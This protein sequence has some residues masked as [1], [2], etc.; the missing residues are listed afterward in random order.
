VNVTFS[1]HLAGALMALSRE[2]WACIFLIILGIILFLVGA[3]IYNSVVGWSGVFLFVAGILALIVLYV[4]HAL[5]KP[6]T[7]TALQNA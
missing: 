3:N 4:Y 5:T 2:D 1:G 6:K 7:H